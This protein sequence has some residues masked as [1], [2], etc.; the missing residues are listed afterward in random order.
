MPWGERSHAGDDRM[1]TKDILPVEKKDGA[2][3]GSAAKDEERPSLD[4]NVAITVESNRRIR[5]AIV[6]VPPARSRRSQ[7]PPSSMQVVLSAR[8]CKGDS[9]STATTS[10]PP[11]PLPPMALLIQTNEPAAAKN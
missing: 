10:S 5:K 7:K 8:R 3:K 1:E 11:R 9:P 6:T 2:R 4:T